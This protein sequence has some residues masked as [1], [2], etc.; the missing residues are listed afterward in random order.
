MCMYLARHAVLE[1]QKGANKHT[2][3]SSN[4]DLGHQSNSHV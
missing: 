1:G 4:W 2:W 3:V